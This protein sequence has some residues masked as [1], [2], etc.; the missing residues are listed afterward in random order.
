[1]PPTI[2]RQLEAAMSTIFTARSRRGSQEVAGAAQALP[3]VPEHAM[4]TTFGWAAC[5]CSFEIRSP[6][7]RSVQTILS[8]RS[9]ATHCR[10]SAP[11]CRPQRRPRLPRTRLC[12]TMS[13]A[14]RAS[15]RGRTALR[16]TAGALLPAV[17]VR[18]DQ[19][20]VR[21][22]TRSSTTACASFRIDSA[23][24]P[25]LSAMRSARRK[26]RSRVSGTRRRLRASIAVAGL[27]SRVGTCCQVQRDRLRG[28]R[29]RVLLIGG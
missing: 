27:R 20:V 4:V 29:Q 10:S 28:R 25:C 23:A 1:M 13:C 6:S 17:D 11:L 7:Y 18:R 9:T 2:Q 14:I 8:M 19:N 16:V 3:W 26:T 21:Y 22:V 24:R 15:A 5:R 12:W